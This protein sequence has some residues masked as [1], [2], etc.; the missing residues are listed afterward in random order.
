MTSNDEWE[1][2]DSKQESK[3]KIYVSDKSTYGDKKGGGDDSDD[4]FEFDSDDDKSKKKKKITES[5][6]RLSVKKHGGIKK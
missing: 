4:S 5:H 3:T 2:S 1:H 6:K